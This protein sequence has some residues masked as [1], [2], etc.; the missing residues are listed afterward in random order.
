MIPHASYS[1]SPLGVTA[2]IVK[3]DDT[4]TIEDSH[5]WEFDKVHKHAKAPLQTLPKAGI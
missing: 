2:E 5:S 4:G 1:L 3:L